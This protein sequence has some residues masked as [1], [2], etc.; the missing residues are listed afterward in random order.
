MNKSKTE[1]L[2]TIIEEKK[3]STDVVIDRHPVFMSCL[4]SHKFQTFTRPHG[5]YVPNWVRE[6]YTTYGGL[7]PQGKKQ[8]VK[9]KPFDYVVVRG[10]KVKCDSDDINA[11]MECTSNISDDYQYIIKKK[12]LETLKK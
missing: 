11:L 1:G 5:P 4:R 6:F 9:F 12:S 2:R 7:V 8:A 3:L 10:K